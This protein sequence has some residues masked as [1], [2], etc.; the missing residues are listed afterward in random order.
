MEIRAHWHS[1][2]E[3]IKNFVVCQFIENNVHMTPMVLI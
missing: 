2:Q 3:I 1:H